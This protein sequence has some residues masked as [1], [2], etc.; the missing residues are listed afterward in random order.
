MA[1]CCEKWIIY[2]LLNP[3]DK[4]RGWIKISDLH[5]ESIQNNKK[6]AGE[7][8]GKQ[9]RKILKRT[10]NKFPPV[11][12]EAMVRLSIFNVDRSRES[13]NNILAMTKSVDEDL[14]A[15][16]SEH[17]QFKHKYMHAEIHL[18]SEKLLD[19]AVVTAKADNI[20]EKSIFISLRKV[21]LFNSVLRLQVYKKGNVKTNVF[22]S[23]V[24]RSQGY[25]KRTVKPNVF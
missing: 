13:P 14:Y 21:V 10:W 18:C 3:T 8:F 5:L 2:H 19:L 1:S 6:S 23:G 24:S 11:E 9:I 25:K 15:L 16:C 17:E 4:I 22:N 7:C 12:L 20:W